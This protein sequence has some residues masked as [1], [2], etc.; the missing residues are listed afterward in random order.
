MPL[1][2]NQSSEREVKVPSGVGMSPAIE[3]HY[4]V[5]EIVK[6]GIRAGTRLPYAWNQ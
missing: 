5:A 2:L 4:T 1:P 3:K 6:L